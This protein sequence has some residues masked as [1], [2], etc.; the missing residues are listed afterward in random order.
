LN[1]LFIF[2]DL[3]PQPVSG[4][5]GGV[6]EQLLSD[7]LSRFVGVMATGVG[8]DVHGQFMNFGFEDEI[9]VGQGI[10]VMAFIEGVFNEISNERA[11]VILVLADGETCCRYLVGF[12]GSMDG[13]TPTNFRIILGVIHFY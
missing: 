7:L 11:V 2:A 5:F 12:D 8:V 6:L 10:V 1:L 9:G 3:G 13:V 4:S